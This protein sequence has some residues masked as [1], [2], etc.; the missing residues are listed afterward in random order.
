MSKNTCIHLFLLCG[1]PNQWWQQI[2]FERLQRQD[3]IWYSNNLEI[4]LARERG[5][6]NHYSQ[7]TGAK[8]SWSRWPE[9]EHPPTT[10]ELVTLHERCFVEKRILGQKIVGVLEANK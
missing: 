9:K 2:A 8:H 3:K 1:E 4:I 10:L 7:L 5:L 6:Q